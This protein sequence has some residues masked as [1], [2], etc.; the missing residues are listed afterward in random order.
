MGENG[1]AG[2]AKTGKERYIKGAVLGEGTFGVVTK[3]EDTLTQK[4][5]AIKKIRLGNY[6]EGI[7]FTAIRE[8]KLLQEL[9]H[10]H[11]IE[12][13]DCFPHKRNLNL[14]FECCESDLEA[15]IKDKFIPL[16]T[17]EIKRLQ[18]IGVRLR[19]AHRRTR[20]MALH[21]ANGRTLMRKPLGH[22]LLPGSN[23]SFVIHIGHSF[24]P[25]DAYLRIELRPSQ[26]MVSPERNQD[27]AELVLLNNSLL[28]LIRGPELPSKVLLELLLGHT[29]FDSER[30]H[31][32][33]VLCG[34]R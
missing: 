4:V 28:D 13:V 24:V 6:R 8:I 27:S 20:Q 22:P 15:V 31:S 7:N 34:H 19:Q 17:P 10:P 33:D 2:K 32:V 11:V 3:A 12:L 26:A 16:G 23:L 14:V 1:K 18:I 21:R 5:V 25:V 29:P 30:R 9:R